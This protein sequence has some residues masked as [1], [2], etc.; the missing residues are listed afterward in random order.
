MNRKPKFN[1][2]DIII[3]K[4]FKKPPSNRVTGDTLKHYSM[5]VDII[6]TIMP[7]EKYVLLDFYDGTQYTFFTADIDNRYKKIA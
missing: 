4:S 7:Y 5:V 6:S 3:H 2:A 1:I